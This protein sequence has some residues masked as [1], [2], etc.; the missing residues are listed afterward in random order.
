VVNLRITPEE[1]QHFHTILVGLIEKAEAGDQNSDLNT[2]LLGSFDASYFLDPGTALEDADPVHF[3]KQF[4]MNDDCLT[5]GGDAGVTQAGTYNIWVGMN[6][7]MSPTGNELADPENYNT[8]FFNA[9]KVDL[10]PGSNRNDLC[11]S[12]YDSMTGQGCIHDLTITDSEGLDVEITHFESESSVGVLELTEIFGC[13]LCSDT[14]YF[15]EQDCLDNNETWA[16]D[17]TYAEKGNCLANAGVWAGNQDTKC[18]TNHGEPLYEVDGSLILYG[19]PHHDDETE[20]ALE[21]NDAL[22]ALHGD[23]ANIDIK[24]SI[25]PAGEAD[26]CADGTDWAPMTIAGDKEASFVCSDTQYTTKETCLANS[27]TWG[28]GN[29]SL[30]PLFKVRDLP[31]GTPFEFHHKLF[32]EDGSDGCSNTLGDWNQYGFFYIQ[33]CAHSSFTESGQQTELEGNNCKKVSVNLIKDDVIEATDGSSY[34]LSSIWDTSTGNSVIGANAAIGTVNHVNLSGATTE[35]YANSNVTGWLNFSI[36]D[37]HAN[38]AAYVS[39]VGSNYDAAITILGTTYW[40]ASDEIAEYSNTWDYSY[41]KSYCYTYN[42][43][44]AGLGLN[45]EL[46][47]GGAAGLE[48]VL[49]IRAVEDSGVAPFDSSTRI[50]V[51][52]VTATPFAG[53][54]MTAGASANLAVLRGGATGNINLVVISVPAEGSLSWGLVD[55]PALVLV[56]NASLDLSLDF[57]SGTISAWVEAW[58]PAWCGC[59]SWCPGYPCGNWGTIW[60][61]N[62]ATWSGFTYSYN[63]YSHT[64]GPITLE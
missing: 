64:V 14:M 47:A 54:T 62:I 43:G 48:T 12:D 49:E 11:Y 34:E 57:L 31:A 8:Q 16:I 3:Q 41:S 38:A 7:A 56:A 29:A 15:K 22:D 25:C 21:D 17:P 27:G 10:E 30:A 39:I 32:L 37:I 55:G 2:C 45:I 35:N 33:M 59:G 51:A 28:P 18:S 1:E 42:Y 40:S 61:D 53:L 13:F 24:Y 44:I 46:C 4:L 50:G 5:G 6:P 36:F 19:F 60:S 52:T 26:E 20:G 63:I 9:A 23:T 58:H